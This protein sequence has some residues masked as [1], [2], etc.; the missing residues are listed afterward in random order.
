ML[1]TGV[2]IA[3]K[4]IEMEDGMDPTRA[5][6]EYDN[7]REEVKILRELDHINIVQFMGTMLEGNIVNIFM[8]LIPGGTI[9]TLLKIYGPFEESLFKNFTQQI[10]EGVNYIHSRN[11]VHRFLK[12]DHFILFLFEFLILTYI[13]RDIKGR[14]IMLMGNGVIKLIDFGCAKRLKK[15]QSS[16]SIKQLLK[17]LKGTP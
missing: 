8:E 6:K 10:L 9:E 14:N 2:I 1:S 7:V 3:V 13:C 16:N 12:L 15:N 4:Q 17:S 5:R 11:V